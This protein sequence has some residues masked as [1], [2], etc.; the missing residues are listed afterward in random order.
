[1]LS[2]HRAKKREIVIKKSRRDPILKM[3]ERYKRDGEGEKFHLIAQK[4]F[5]IFGALILFSLIVN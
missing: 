5:S 2:S 1:M 3:K 4:L